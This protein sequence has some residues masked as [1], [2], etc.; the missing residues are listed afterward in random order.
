MAGKYDQYFISGLPPDH[1]MSP[2]QVIA[3]LSG[4]DFEG[5]HQYFIRWIQPT[6][7]GME[8]AKEWAQVGHGTHMHKTP[9]VV[10]HVGTNPDDPYD[11][12][13]EVVMYMGEEMEKHVITR[14]T[15]IYIPA[16]MIHAP[17]IIK[18]VTRPWIFMTVC[19]E[20]HH[21][22]KSFPELTPPEEVDNVVYMDQGYDSDELRVQQP[23]VLRGT[24]ARPG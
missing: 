23:A 5:C 8:P 13:G 14:S 17:W 16:N 1:F 7:V 6:P 11:L 19:Q 2:R 10:V 3:G 22:E 24:D 15:L 18:K 9:E 20:S 21:T 4:D 12:G